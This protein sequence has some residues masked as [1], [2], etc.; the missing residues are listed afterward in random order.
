VRLSIF[1]GK[2]IKMKLYLV[3]HAIAEKAAAGSDDDRALTEVGKEKMAQV[4]VGLRKLKIFPPLILTSPLR[5]ARETAEIL[6]EG[7]G[8]TMEVV[9]ELA[10]G[11]SPAATIA[12]V[13]RHMRLAGLVMVGHQPDLGRLASH[14]LTGTDRFELE[15]KKGGVACLEVETGGSA[16]HGRLLW[17][18]PPRILRSL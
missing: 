3:R 15:F 13:G 4:V 17:L 16:L 2:R 6:A 9:K 14:L 1:N 8:G 12:V 10:P 18:V 5:R 7:L 11:S